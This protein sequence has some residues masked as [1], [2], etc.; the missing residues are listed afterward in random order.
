M[1]KL[2][3]APESKIDKETITIYGA[4]KFGEDSLVLGKT[5]ARI[6]FIELWKFLEVNLKQV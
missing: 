2:I 6:I 5:R 3:Y 1:E 4:G